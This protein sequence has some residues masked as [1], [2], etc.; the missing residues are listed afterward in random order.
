MCGFRYNNVGIKL[1]MRYTD[2]RESLWRQ[3][4]TTDRSLVDR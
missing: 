1:K 4:V 3:G 2:P